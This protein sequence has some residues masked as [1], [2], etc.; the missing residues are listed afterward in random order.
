MQWS[1]WT[2]TGQPVVVVL[3]VVAAGAAWR[4]AAAWAVMD[5]QAKAAS[6]EGAADQTHT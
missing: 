3:V 1:A 6:G 2:A 4:V 5:W